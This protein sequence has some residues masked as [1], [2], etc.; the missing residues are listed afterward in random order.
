ME[1]REFLNMVKPDLEAMMPGDEVTVR[2]IQKLQ[3]KSYYGIS[4]KPEGRIAA[5][6]LNLE[7]FH[8]RFEEGQDYRQ[9]LKGIVNAVREALAQDIQVPL[10]SIKDYDQVK[11]RLIVQLVGR[12]GNEDRLLTIPHHDMEDMS[13]VYHI[14]LGQMGGGIGCVLITNEMLHGYGISAEKLH[15]DALKSAQERQPFI[16]RGMN[17][18]M[19]EFMGT[20][21]SEVSG[22][23]NLYVAT[24]PEMMNGACVIAYPGF[25]EAAA[26]KM[27]GNF[28]ILPSSLHEVIMV[29][30]NGMK[31]YQELEAI[32]ANV[33]ETQVLP[34]DQLSGNVYHYDCHEK[35]FELAAKYDG[36]ARREE[37]ERPSVLKSLEEHKANQAPRKSGPSVSRKESALSM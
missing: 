25:M 32:V 36:R 20:E 11:E 9:I 6:S 24:N 33:N 15:Q 10:E 8:C 29:P 23:S 3:G 21:P 34:E 35:V 27:N 17:E 37:E 31:S 28:F 30:E 18:I 19:A 2:N 12:E 5:A 7:S 16:I 13:L 14:D 26:E 4:V 22:A 1:Y